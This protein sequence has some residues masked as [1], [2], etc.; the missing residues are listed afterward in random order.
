MRPS[1][2]AAVCAALATSASA[3]AELTPAE[4]R[5]LRGTW[6]VVQYAKAQAL[7]LD[8]VVQPQAADGAA[9]LALGFVD[10]RCKLVFTL[11]D[12]P[13]AE[14]AIRRIEPDLL[15]TALELMA[16]H[17]LGHCRRYLDG[18]W[19]G[20]PSGFS[21]TGPAEQAIR[22][23]EAY[24]DLVGLAWTKQHHPQ[25][26]A[27][28]HAWLVAERE[29]DHVPGSPH[30][31]LAWVRLADDGGTLAQRSIFSAADALWRAGL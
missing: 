23:E 2:V 22:R 20:L 14:A 24:G 29:L 16:A 21:A 28:L 31:T 10:G 18:A 17:E 6:P 27:R 15:D 13:E 12:N 19:L 26:Y 9:P 3:A 1:F 8:V 7:P 25:H 11:R 5:W 30:D 4:M